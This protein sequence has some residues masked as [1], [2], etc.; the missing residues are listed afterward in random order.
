NGGN[1][2]KLVHSWYEDALSGSRRLST[3]LGCVFFLHGL[4]HWRRCSFSFLHLDSQMTQNSII[5]FETGFDF[6]QRFAVAFDVQAN[7]VCLGQFLDHV[8]QL[9]TA[10]VFDT[11]YD[12]TTGGNDTFVALDHGGH[13]LAL[14]RMDNK[15]DFVM[16]HVS[17]LW[18]IKNRP[19]RRQTS[20]GREKR[21]IIRARRTKF[22]CLS[23]SRRP[24]TANSCNVL[25]ISLYFTA[26]CIKLQTVYIYSDRIFL[27]QLSGS[28]M[29]KLTARQEQILNLIRDAIDNT[30][31]PPTRAEIAAELGFRSANAAEEHL[32]ALARKG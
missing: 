30:G 25:S 12:T 7:V 20:V 15:Y 19:P 3:A 28:A 27:R 22:N 10:P 21:A 8:C 23:Q 1:N 31:F 17:S 13:L 32:Q 9:A 18:T 16:T 24:T 5:E 4:H 6:G 26:Y 11:V 14:I 29:I 2:L